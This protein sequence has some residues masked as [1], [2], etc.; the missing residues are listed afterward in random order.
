[1]LEEE[2][3]LLIEGMQ[4][5]IEKIAQEVLKSNEM[6]LQITGKPSI[7]LETRRQEI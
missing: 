1:M 7:E 3:D 5:S 6:T 2:R 4:R